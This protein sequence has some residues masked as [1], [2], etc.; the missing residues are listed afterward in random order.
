MTGASPLLLAHFRHRAALMLG[1]ETSSKIANILTRSF[2]LSVAKNGHVT[3]CV[4]V[5][6]LLG[7]DVEKVLQEPGVNK[8]LPHWRRELQKPRWLVAALRLAWKFRKGRYIMV[9]SGRSIL[10]ACRLL[11]ILRGRDIFIL[12]IGSPKKWRGNCADVLLRAQHEREAEE[13]ERNPYPWNPQQVWIDAPICQPLPVEGVAEKTVTVLLGGLNITYGDDAESY[14]DFLEKL[15]ELVE[16]VPVSIVF[17]RRTKPEVKKAVQQR[18]EKTSARLIDADDR[19]GFLN[20]CAHAG[21]F[22]ITPDSITMVAEAFAT[23]KPVYTAKLPVKRDGTRNRR[24]IETALANGHIEEFEGTISF[25][26]RKVDL[27]YIDRARRAIS[28]SL[29]AWQKTR[30]MG[31]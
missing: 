5:S 14:S 18:F 19:E 7:L 17:S 3:Q 31:A 8:A 21:A 15:T 16:A 6:E 25:A 20:A 11:K 22:V 10:P 12:F 4:A 24:Y 30:D 26:P 28:A 1:T 13:D 23:G 27:S 29:E 9:A 2:I